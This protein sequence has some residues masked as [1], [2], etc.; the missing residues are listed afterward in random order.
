MPVIPS[1]PRTEKS[2]DDSDDQQSSTSIEV[3]NR[4]AV[5]CILYLCKTIDQP[6]S[7]RTFVFFATA[8]SANAG[9]DCPTVGLILR[10]GMSPSSFDLYQEL[11]R[12][13][14]RPGNEDEDTHITPVSRTSSTF[15]AIQR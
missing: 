2:L 4:L 10:K 7:K 15:F 13:A 1:T 12:L 5:I 9:I 6:L 3:F 11:S 8:G 14:R